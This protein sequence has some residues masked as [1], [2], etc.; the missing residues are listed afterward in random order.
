MLKV[1]HLT[2]K[3]GKLAACDD[4]DFALDDGSVTCCWAP[5]ER[6]RAR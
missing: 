4:V 2:K 6:A 3:Y 1:S 5:T